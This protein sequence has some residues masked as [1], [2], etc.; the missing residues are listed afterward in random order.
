MSAPALSAPIKQKKPEE[1]LS[2]FV[3]G[4]FGLFIALGAHY[5]LAPHHFG[6]KHDTELDAQFLA[7]PANKMIEDFL[8]RLF[9]FSDL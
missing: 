4:A 2:L 8:V 7:S 5:L 3:L 1:K 9:K 6:V